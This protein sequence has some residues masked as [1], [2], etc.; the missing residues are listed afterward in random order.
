M[1]HLVRCAHLVKHRSD[2]G[3]DWAWAETERII[4]SGVLPQY[5]V[6]WLAE[7][8]NSDSSDWVRDVMDGMKK[9]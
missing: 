5:F 4:E 7:E 6:T 9:K 1:Q 2:L 3:L 8:R